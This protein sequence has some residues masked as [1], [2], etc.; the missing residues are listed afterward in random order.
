MPTKSVLLV[1]VSLLFASPALAQFVPSNRLNDA[2]AR[3]SRDADDFANATYN[4]YT[5]S[6]RNNRNDIESMML[7][8]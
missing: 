8:Q 1:V 6:N 4:T 7:A 3:L 5:T 2:A